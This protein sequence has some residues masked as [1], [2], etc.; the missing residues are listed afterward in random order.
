[1]SDDPKKPDVGDMKIDAS[2]LRGIV[3]DLPPGGRIGLRKSQANFPEMIAE[4]L[5]NHPLF[6]VAAGIRDEEPVA[7][8]ASLQQM[9]DID[10]LLPAAEKLVELLQETR[11]VIDDRLQ[12]QVFTIAE[13]VE[14]R[15]KMMGDN[16]LRARYAKTLAYRSAIGNKAARTRQR[17]LAG[18]TPDENA[19]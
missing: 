12:K 14:R 1:M 10:A 3:V 4:L 9:A 13:T 8:Q 7:I 2:H 6:G 19:N 16:E 11:A 5:S 17:N 18:T 15:A